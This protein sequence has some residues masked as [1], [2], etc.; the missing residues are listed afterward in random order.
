MEEQRASTRNHSIHPRNRIEC[1]SEKKSRTHSQHPLPA[2]TDCW[3]ESRRS[4]LWCW[5]NNS[6]IY[7]GFVRM[8]MCCSVQTRCSA[9]LGL[10]SG[11]VGCCERTSIKQGVLGLQISSEWIDVTCKRSGI[12]SGINPI[13][14]WF[15]FP[16]EYTANYAGTFWILAVAFLVEWW[17]TY[18]C[19]WKKS[20]LVFAAS[21][22]NEERW[23]GN[24]NKARVQKEAKQQRKKVPTT[25]HGVW[26]LW[27]RNFVSFGRLASDSR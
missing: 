9:V 20:Y 14:L 6:F 2:L 15:V 22:S 21:A 19:C 25:A 11:W 13:Y 12:T 27:L 5:K 1:R 3:T 7:R 8:R 24:P 4:L 26:L 16:S 10:W 18:S 17:K 23:K